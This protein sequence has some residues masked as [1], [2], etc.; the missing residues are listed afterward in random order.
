M[1]NQPKIKKMFPGAVTYQGFY[2]FYNYMIE[3]DA[4]HIFVIKGGPGVGKSTFMKKIGQ[5]MLEAGYNLEYHC[6]SSDNS[7][8]DGLVIPELNIALLDG[9]APHVVD[10]KNPGAVDEII[11]LGEYWN[12]YQMLQL[13]D[14]IINCNR[15]VNRFFQ[16]A[17]FSL[18]DAKNALDE[19]EFYIQPHQDW[20]KINQMYLKVEKELF[21]NS[22]KNN[23]KGKER[24]LFAW[25]HTPQGKCQF[26][27][28]LLDGIQTLYTLQGQP[29]T[30]KSSFLS[31]I[32]ARAQLM[33]LN[34]EFYHNTLEPEKLDM[35]ILQ[36]LEVALVITASP[37]DYLPEF[38]GNQISL[39]FD[40]S[41]DQSSL[42]HSQNELDSCRERVDHSLERALSNS[43]SAKRVHDLMETYYIPAMDF[44]AIEQK[45]LETLQRIFDMAGE[46]AIAVA[47]P[48]IQT[49]QDV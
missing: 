20:P 23:G 2:S 8:I 38:S 46:Q 35:I 42:I 45:R 16:A 31:K 26:I 37:Y 39:D 29:G 9:T 24:H 28:T 22:P 3:P 44:K 32:A 18:K 27:D 48:D 17:Y 47:S 41:L 30:G 43:Q 11:N 49:I 15:Q 6:C 7:S 21:K 13:K 12:E 19:W 4:R 5:S 40:K 1:S 10:P 25:A 34:V 33:N 14:D 36:E